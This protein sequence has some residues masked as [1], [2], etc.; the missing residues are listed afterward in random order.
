MMTSEGMASRVWDQAK[1]ERRT[2]A[3]GGWGVEGC[4]SQSTVWSFDRQRPKEGTQAFCQLA[5]ADSLFFLK[6][7]PGEITMGTR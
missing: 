4:T 2:A 3:G 6:L 5:R 1:R 7:K